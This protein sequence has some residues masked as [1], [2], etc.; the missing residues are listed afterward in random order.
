[1]KAYFGSLTSYRVF[2]VVDCAEGTSRQFALQPQSGFRY[3][4]HKVTKIF[5]T[6]MHGKS[7]SI[8]DRPPACLTIYAAPLQPTTSWA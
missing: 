3:R 8:H 2:L 5:I 7:H 4:P 6:H 1:M